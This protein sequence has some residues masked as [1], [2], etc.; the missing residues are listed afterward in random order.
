MTQSSR[1]VYDA[2]TWL[3]WLLA[4]GLLVLLTRNPLYLLLLLAVSRVVQSVCEP[5]EPALWRLPFWRIAALILTFSTLFNL[6][7]AHLGETVLTTLPAG[8]WL[9]GGHLTLEAAVYGFVAG[10]SLVALLSFFLAFNTIVPAQELTGLTPGALYELGL[11][12]LIALTY[13]PETARQFGRIRDAQAIRGHHLRRVSDWRPIVIPLLIGGLERAMNLAE[14]MVAR[15]YGSTEAVAMPLR[16][17]LLLLAGLALALGGALRLAWGGGDGWA[18]VLAGVL[19]VGLAYRDLSRR[20][21]RTRYRPRR[22]TWADAFVIG[23][24]LLPLALILPLPFVTGA[25]LD[26]SPYPRLALPPFSVVAG[27][28]LMGLAAPAVLEVAR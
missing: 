3:V 20:A 12:M 19:A 1:R 2:R 17:R 9:I 28:L 26:Y 8:W 11:V 21:P 24:A 5:P 27:L 4:G 22:L 15:G 18:L 16:T 7:T 25:G 23:V 10:L 13:V 6:L 14:T